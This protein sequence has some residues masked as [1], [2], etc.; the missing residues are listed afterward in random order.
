MHLIRYADDMIVTSKSRE[1][2][3]KNK[4]IIIEF[5]KERGLEL[6]EQKTVISHITD[7]FNF[8]GFNIKRFPFNK[9]LNSKTN[10]KTVLI[11]KPSEKGL[12]KLKQKLKNIFDRSKPMEGIVRELN[13]ILRG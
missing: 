4:Q 5:L 2:A 9:T 1:T 11:I 13:P 6:N 10:Q 7:G 8:L 3:E 12:V